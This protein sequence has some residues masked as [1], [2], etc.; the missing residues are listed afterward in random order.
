LLALARRR[1]RSQAAARR[2]ASPA[3]FVGGLDPTQF[4]NEAIKPKLGP[5]GALLRYEIDYRCVRRISVSVIRHPLCSTSDS[6]L[7]S[8]NE[9]ESRKSARDNC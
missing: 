9:S 6:I 4:Y 7:F 5:I 1:P 2:R 3:T 8:K